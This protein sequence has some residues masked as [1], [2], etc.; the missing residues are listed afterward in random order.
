MREDGLRC[1][2]LLVCKMQ[3]RRWSQRQRQHG[4]RSTGIA[5][6]AGAEQSRAARCAGHAG[7]SPRGVRQGQQADQHVQIGGKL[8][9]LLPAVVAAH[10]R[11]LR[12]GWGGVGGQGCVRKAGGQ[13]STAQHNTVQHSIAQRSAPPW[14]CA[15][16]RTRGIPASAACRRWYRPSRLPVWRERAGMGA[17]RWAIGMAA[18]VKPLSGDQ[19]PGTAAA[20]RLVG[21]PAQRQ[22]PASPTRSWLWPRA[23]HA[24][25][26]YQHSGSSRPMMP[27]R[28]S[29]LLP[30]NPHRL[31]QWQWHASPR[32]M[33]PTRSSLLS[34]LRKFSTPLSHRRARC[35]S[36]YASHLRYGRRGVRGRVGQ[37]ALE[38]GCGVGQSIRPV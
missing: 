5:A 17:Q 27:T 11:P 6:A 21:T 2:I 13:H 38:R 29:L 28:S 31:Q 14:G 22:Q 9:Q 8:A 36:Q 33:M 23:M 4:H 26:Q 37:G 20:A 16:R 34:M 1:Y 24:H 25:R 18:L 32:P 35:A 10:A 7:R 19:G 15:S 30:R 12:G 3:Q